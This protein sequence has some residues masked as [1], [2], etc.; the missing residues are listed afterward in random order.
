MKWRK[1]EVSNI[2]K[3]FISFGATF[4]V[5]CKTLCISTETQEVS[6]D[7]LNK[8]LA[9]RSGNL[10]TVTSILYF[11]KMQLLLISVLA[12]ITFKTPRSTQHL[13]GSSKTQLWHTYSSQETKRSDR[14]TVSWYIS[15]MLTVKNQTSQASGGCHEILCGNNHP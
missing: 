2:N 14:G 9:S 7:L 13:T 11:P 15:S 1:A 6:N 8:I 3:L 4:T 10:P 5:K 12:G